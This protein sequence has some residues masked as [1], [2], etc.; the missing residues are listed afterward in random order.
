VA[1]TV[2]ETKPEKTETK[3]RRKF[4]PLVLLASI[5][6]LGSLIWTTY[7]LLDFFQDGGID[8]ATFDWKDVSIVGL[9]AAATADIAWSL[10]MFAQYRGTRLM[11]RKAWGKKKFEVDILPAIGWIEVL[12]VAALLFAHGKDVGGGEAAFAAVL[13]IL[14][15]FSWMVA[16]ADLKDPSE[17]T[18]E[19]KQEIAE[20]ERES[21]R[22]KARMEATAK[23]HQA[24]ME[25]KRRENEAKLED[26]KLANEMML[27]DKEADFSIKELELRQENRLKALDISLK[28]ELRMSELDARAQVDIKRE[29]HDWEMSLRRP[30]TISGQVIPQ[31][32]LAQSSSMLEIEGAQQDVEP[33]FLD[34]AKL[35]LSP[36]EQRRAQMARDYYTADA[37]HNGTVTKAAFAK[38]NGINPPRVT[39][40]TKDFPVEWFFEHGLA[41]WT[42]P[43]G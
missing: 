14:T 5:L 31:R 4:S 7:S 37:L 35:G 22:T 9:S 15:K 40:A 39:E 6:S 11:V 1:E 18:E 20:M 43:Q 41:T 34:L 17:L 3:G 12:F 23:K 25:Q 36:A 30:R 28:A 29:D 10:T 33:D 2:N 32:G 21:R 13:P 19:E 42:S 8:P 24:E 27:L 38:A 26:K 16:L